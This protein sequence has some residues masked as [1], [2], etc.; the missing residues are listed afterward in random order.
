MDVPGRPIPPYYH[1]VFS[2]V[3]VVGVDVLNLF[4]VVLVMNR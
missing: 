3:P 1:V 2:T 4:E